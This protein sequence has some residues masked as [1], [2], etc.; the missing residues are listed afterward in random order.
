VNRGRFQPAHLDALCSGTLRVVDASVHEGNEVVDSWTGF[1]QAVALGRGAISIPDGDDGCDLRYVAVDDPHYWRG[2]I[3]CMTHP[4][5]FIV[6]PFGPTF[7]APL[8]SDVE[9]LRPP[10]ADWSH[11]MRSTN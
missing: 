5:W 2:E 1:G 4:G 10:E 7:D 6:V 11:P 8:P 9:R 3:H